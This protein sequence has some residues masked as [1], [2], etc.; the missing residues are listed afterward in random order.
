[1]CRFVAYLGEKAA[2]LSEVVDKPKNSLINQSRSAR[3]GLTELNADGF[4]I[5][6]Y[7]KNISALPAVFK[8][9]QPAWNDHNLGN[10][11]RIIESKCFIS[12]VRA[13]TVGDVSPFNCHPFKYQNLLFAH[14]GTIDGFNEFKHEF[15]HS[16]S[17]EP[18]QHIRGHTD[19]EHYFALLLSVMD[20]DL[21]L[22]SF[23]RVYKMVQKTLGL[24]AKLQAGHSS[25]QVARINTVL[26][27]GERMIALRYISDTAHQPNTLYI[28]TGEHL[29]SNSEG[30]IMKQAT[31]N[32]KAVLVASE[33]LT[34]VV[35][36]WTEVPLNYMVMVHPNLT[37]EAKAL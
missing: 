17:K 19:S 16:I 30:S 34:D 21:D 11:T 5:G 33:K 20:G 8:S 27:D 1:M 22:S 15:V 36:E 7:N 13:S 6:W 28:S 18:Y 31:K 12:H 29:E 25:S 35:G 2:L 4:G 9:I 26:T 3:E 14:N 23:N 37:I 24:V 10:L 32:R